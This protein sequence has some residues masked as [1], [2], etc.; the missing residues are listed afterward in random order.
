MGTAMPAA[1][2]SPE[3]SSPAVSTVMMVTP[4]TMRAAVSGGT[5]ASRSSASRM[6]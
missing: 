4:E 5:P 2:S 3:T 1:M 6:R